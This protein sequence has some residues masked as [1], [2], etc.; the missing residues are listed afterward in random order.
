MEGEPQKD[1]PMHGYSF[2][3][4]PLLALTDIFKAPCSSPLSS[5][6]L[7]TI[8]WDRGRQ[9]K[10]KPLLVSLVAF[11]L[12]VRSYP[13]TGMNEYLIVRWY[14]LPQNRV[15]YPV[16]SLHVGCKWNCLCRVRVFSF[17]NCIP[18]ATGSKSQFTGMFDGEAKWRKV[19]AGSH[20]ESNTARFSLSSI[21]PH[22]IEHV[23]YWQAP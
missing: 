7:S 21:S 23:I 22:A 8:P 17:I 4:V 16:L 12:V 5:V 9:Y 15:L 13:D 20:W 3:T 6:R 19:K 18:H 10:W 11:S 2:L 1:P 14:M